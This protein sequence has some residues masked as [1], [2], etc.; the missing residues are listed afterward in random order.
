MRHSLLVIIS[1]II[2]VT[3]SHNAMAQESTYK[4][5]AGVHLGLSG[6]LGDANE[7]NMFKHPGYAA[8][9]SF[10]YLID[11]RWALRGVFSTASLSGNTA[12]WEDVLPAGAQYEFKSQIYDLTARGEFNFFAYGIGETYKRLKRWSPYLTLGIGAT[13]ASCDGETAVALNIPMGFGVKYKL[14]QRLNLGLEF[15][16]TKVFGDNVDGKKLSDLYMIKSSFLKNTDWHSM[17]TFSITYEF[18]ERCTT[19]HYVD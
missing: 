18:G 3:M 13:I 19:C 5:D 12:D 16:M 17:I 9:A 10:R 15:T 11:T 14:K 2:V 6:Y 1:A 7:S 8:G 4:F